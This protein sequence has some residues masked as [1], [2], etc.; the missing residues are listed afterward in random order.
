M[1]L[2]DRDLAT[3]LVEPEGE[4]S[5][6]LPEDSAKQLWA[7]YDRQTRSP[8]FSVGWP[9]QEALTELRVLLQPYPKEHPWRERLYLKEWS[10]KVKRKRGSKKADR[11]GPTDGRIASEPELG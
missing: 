5:E 9:L 11:I 2:E 1:G 3:F 6:A 4:P 8:Y 10:R 7:I